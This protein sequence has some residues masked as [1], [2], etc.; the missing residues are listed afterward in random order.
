[1]FQMNRRQHITA[2]DLYNYKKCRLRPFLDLNGDHTQRVDVH[3]LIELLWEAGVQYEAQVL[4]YL[5]DKHS[6]KVFVSIDP[7]SPVSAVLIEN[8]LKAM[9]EGADFIYQGVLQHGDCLGRPDL[10]VKQVGKS[11]LGD[12]FYHPTDVKLAQKDGEWDDGNEKMNLEHL[13]QLYFYGQ[14]L[15]G[16]QGFLPKKGY[17]YKSKSRILSANLQKVPNKY[18]EAMELLRNYLKGEDCGSGPAI[19]SNCSMCPWND[20]CNEVVQKTNDVTRLYFVGGGMKYGLKELGISSMSDMAKA[21]PE[22]LFPEV[23]RLKKEGH[24]WPSMPDKFILDANRRAKVFLSNEPVLYSAPNFPNF[25]VE[26]HYDIENDPTSDFVYLHGV[27]LVEKE[28]KPQYRAFFADSPGQEEKITRDLFEYF[29]KYPNAPIYHY[30]P[31]EKATLKRLCKKYPDLDSKIFEDLFKDGGRAIDLYAWIN[32]NTDW[33]LTSYSLKATCKYLGFRWSAE[34]AGGA[35]SIIWMNEYL[36]GNK[37]MKPKVI[38]Y[39]EEDCLATHF[40]KEW[41]EKQ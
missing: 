30:A 29:S 21:D 24:F 1:L 35:N 13:W 26:I 36:A 2:S 33:P 14:L 34:D 11:D 7:N 16:A 15:H 3:P 4:E 12:Y 22:T 23:S 8:T 20:R 32:Q 9:K 38:Q 37:E 18:S 31:H 27:L 41:L 5:K 28:K 40:L 17:I 39:N 6:D 19:S 10:L 25:P